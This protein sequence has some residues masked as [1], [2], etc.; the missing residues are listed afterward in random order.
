MQSICGGECSHPNASFRRPR[1]KRF[2]PKYRRPS[3]KISKICGVCVWQHSS[4]RNN[5]NDQQWTKKHHPKRQRRLQV[6]SV[7]HFAGLSLL[8]RPIKFQFKDQV[9]VWGQRRISTKNLR[10]CVA[11]HVWVARRET[12]RTRGRFR[13]RVWLKSES[14][15]EWGFVIY[16]S[17]AESRGRAGGGSSPRSF[18]ERILRGGPVVW[19][20]RWGGARGGERWRSAE[21][22]RH[23]FVPCA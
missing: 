22:R 20:S 21:R 10:Q 12:S 7:T 4:T 19:N 17:R 23:L 18:S 1:A 13:I 5:Y 16:S 6:Y 15:Y 14:V 3:P 8:Q 11:T 9:A 2:D